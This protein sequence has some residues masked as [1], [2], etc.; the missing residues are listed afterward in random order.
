MRGKLLITGATGFVGQAVIDACDEQGLAWIGQTS[1]TGSAK[2]FPADLSAPFDWSDKLH[3]IDTII[4]LA[5]MA[6]APVKDEQAKHTMRCIN[7][8]AAAE[9]A[10]HAVRAGVRQF[11]FVSSVNSYLYERS[12]PGA[13]YYGYCKKMAE[14][15]VLAEAAGSDMAV[16]ILRPCLMYGKGAKGNFASMMKW[17]W[18]SVPLPL[19]SVKNK[20]SFMHVRNFADIILHCLSAREKAAG[21]FE[22]TDGI[23][24]STPELLLKVAEALGKPARLIPFPPSLLRLGATVVGKKEMLEKLAGDMA[25][26]GSKLAT[27]LNWRRRYQ[28]TDGFEEMAIDFARKA[29]KN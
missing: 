18:R 6:H 8:D 15:A 16:T 22:V 4:H 2:F 3:G 25:I 5:G 12:L 21:I 1:G 7:I 19:A 29:S 27:L 20:R 13:S 9:L 17:L 24:Y 28:D 10:N 23:D 14:E 26:D 11:I